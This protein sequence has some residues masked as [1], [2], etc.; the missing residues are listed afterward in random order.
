V[1][2]NQ[3]DWKPLVE[4]LVDTT[5][6][7]VKVLRFDEHTKRAPS[8]LLKFEAGSSYPYHNHPAGEELFV[9]EGDVM[10]EGERLEAGDYLYTPSN[11]KHFVKSEHGCVLLLLIPEEVEIL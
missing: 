2:T 3:H 5:G 7:F 1:K 11:F 6:I 8:I 10:I 9:L 4:N